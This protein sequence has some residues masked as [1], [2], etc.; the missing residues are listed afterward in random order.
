MKKNVQLMGLRPQ[1]PTGA[2]SLDP[3]LNFTS[4]ST[5]LCLS[6]VYNV[7]YYLALWEEGF[8]KRKPKASFIYYNKFDFI[9]ICDQI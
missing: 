7:V 4:S 3:E 9:D 5:R 8:F 6:L 2:L 1:A